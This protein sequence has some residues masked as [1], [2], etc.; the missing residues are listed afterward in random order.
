MLGV[1]EPL[2][3]CSEMALAA[4]SSLLAILAIMLIFCFFLPVPVAAGFEPLNVG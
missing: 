4:I 2:S 3:D 1:V